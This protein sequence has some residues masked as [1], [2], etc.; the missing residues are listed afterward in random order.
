M[1]EG[2]FDPIF[3][4]WCRERK[5]SLFVFPKAYRNPSLTSKHLFISA[6]ADMGFFCCPN[7]KD[8]F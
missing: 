7:H 3:L 2:Q 8:V 5:E 4:C 6:L 1:S